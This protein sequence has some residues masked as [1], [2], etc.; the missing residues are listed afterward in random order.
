MSDQIVEKRTKLW[1]GHDCFCFCLNKN[2][3]PS[4]IVK[5]SDKQRIFVLS[6]PKGPF[7]LYISDSESEN[8]LW[9]LPLTLWSFLMVLLSFSFSL[10]L[11]VNGPFVQTLS[12]HS[13]Y[14]LP[15]NCFTFSIIQNEKKQKL[16]LSISSSFILYERASFISFSFLVISSV[17]GR[18]I[19]ANITV[20][21]HLVNSDSE[22]SWFDTN[23]N[24]YT[25][26]ARPCLWEK[27]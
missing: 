3:E 12:C 10:S 13:I 21:F 26:S 9:C 8:F 25:L 27:K 20:S 14:L 1:W 15:L 24:L 16:T 7:T 6:N 22:K 18:D 4:A 5:Q 17:V 2:T 23:S 19:P 11:S